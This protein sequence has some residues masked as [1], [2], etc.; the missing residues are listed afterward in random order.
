MHV[1]RPTHERRRERWLT[2][3]S[4]RFAGV[5]PSPAETKLL[6]VDEEAGQQMDQDMELML[7][8]PESAASKQP[9]SMMA[10]PQ[11][12]PKA[13]E[14]PAEGG[15]TVPSP[16]PEIDEAP[17]IM[18]TP[19][20]EEE[21]EEDEIE[22]AEAEPKELVPLATQQEHACDQAPAELEEGEGEAPE[23]LAAKAPASAP[24]PTQEPTPV[25]SRRHSAASAGP[26]NRTSSRKSRNGGTARIEMPLGED[27]RPI[28]A[29]LGDPIVDEVA[30]L[31]KRRSSRFVDTNLYYTGFRLHGVN[32]AVG[33][34]VFFAVVRNEDPY[35]SR[36][37]KCYQTESGE[38]MM[39]TTTY[40]RAMDI[41]KVAK[42]WKDEILAV[43]LRRAHLDVLGNR[44]LPAS[45]PPPPIP[46]P[47]D[48]AG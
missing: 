44:I 39:D 21:M 27:G 47:F 38:A 34:H 1:V 33:D 30:E 45:P 9:K 23:A 41:R 4:A 18:A 40:G 25:K 36:I 14:H 31:S 8:S 35:I 20:D 16:G 19:V 5:L 32:Y 6:E 17:L 46:L 22:E 12:G 42:N 28:F 2:L 7:D 43:R 3:A 10:L 13:N 29:F 11:G 37:Q 24:A 15:D 48:D 26:A